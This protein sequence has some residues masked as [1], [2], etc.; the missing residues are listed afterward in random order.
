MQLKIKKELYSRQV[1]LKA[2]YHFTDKYYL[3]LDSTQ[4]DY[5]ISF[6][7]QKG[8]R[9]FELTADEFHCYNDVEQCVCD[10]RSFSCVERKADT[11]TDGQRNQKSERQT[12]CKSCFFHVFLQNPLRI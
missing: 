11:D 6:K 5:I 3:Y 4:D 9:G 7:P 10:C 8:N 2:A 1:V 12:V